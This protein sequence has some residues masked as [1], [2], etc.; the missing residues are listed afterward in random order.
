MFG[1]LINSWTLGGVAAAGVFIV[2]RK[3]TWG[4][5]ILVG[6]QAM[7]ITYGIAT[8]QY[9]FIASGALF[10]TINGN[11]WRRWRR[12]DREAREVAELS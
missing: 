1:I 6:A 8:R 12:D 11:N 7:W 2:G 4:W 9:G 10:A 5:L 3:K